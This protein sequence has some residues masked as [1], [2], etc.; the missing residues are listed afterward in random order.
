[1]MK[2]F[3]RTSVGKSVCLEW[4]IVG[5]LTAFAALWIP[6]GSADAQEAS[7]SPEGEDFE[8]SVKLKIGNN[9]IAN[10]V[11]VGENRLSDLIPDAP[12]STQ[13]FFFDPE[14]ASFVSDTFLLGK[15]LQLA[16]RV[17]EPGQGFIVQTRLPITLTFKGILVQEPEIRSLDAGIHVIGSVRPIPATFESL[18]GRAPKIGEKLHEGI[19]LGESEE[20]FESF[21]FTESGW[22]PRAPKLEVGQAAWVELLVPSLERDEAQ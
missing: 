1:M 20:N 22:R 5:S 7:E 12:Q 3:A 10:H 18:V 9:H 8:Y 17:V 21:E 6:D 4:M 13:I 14:K 15:W 19:P 16:D 2:G 11:L